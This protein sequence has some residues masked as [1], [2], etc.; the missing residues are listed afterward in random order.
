MKR[1]R[2]AVRKSEKMIR[3][4]GRNIVDKKYGW[5]MK[6]GTDKR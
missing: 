1:K 3:K 5:A 4:K 2:D 6:I